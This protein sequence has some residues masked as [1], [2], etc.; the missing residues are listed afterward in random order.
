MTSG[1]IQN[2]KVLSWREDR[3]L[4]MG[5]DPVRAFDIAC[6]ILDLHQLEDLLGRGCPPQ[7]ALAIVQ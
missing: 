7:T 1:D 5:F 3:L 4:A 2:D 6:T